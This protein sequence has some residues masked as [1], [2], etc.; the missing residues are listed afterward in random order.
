[1]YNFTIILCLD[2][3]TSD[4][5]V[6]MYKI[7]IHTHTHE[8]TKHAIF[9]F[10]LRLVNL[11]HAA[12]RRR[13]RISFRSV[14]T[15][16]CWGTFNFRIFLC[17]TAKKLYKMYNTHTCTISFSIT[18][19]ICIVMWCMCS[20]NSRMNE[21]FMCSPTTS[22]SSSLCKVKNLTCNRGVLNT[23]THTQVILLRSLGVYMH[24]I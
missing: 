4:V 9:I 22:S 14:F 15:A 6:C 21:Q 24:T 12:A 10:S 3:Y 16:Y 17:I 19:C 2:L 1:M 18:F 5:Y 20:T 13:R 11:M 8:R 23:H 7:Q